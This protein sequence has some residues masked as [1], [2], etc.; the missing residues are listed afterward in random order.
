MKFALL[1]LG[2]CSALGVSAQRCIVKENPP[3]MELQRGLKSFVR[4]TLPN[5]VIVIPVVIHVLYNNAAQNI[6]V[7]QI[8]S[9]LLALNLDFRRR[10][11]DTANT[12][13]PFKS[14]AGDA[15]IAFCLAKQD[16]DGK[17]TTGIVRKYTRETEFF[18]DD[19]M[20][21]SKT[22]GDEPWDPS[23]YL[24][25]WVCNLFG[26]TLGYA[27][28]PGGDPALDGVVIQ[29]H[30]FGNEK[31]AIPPFNKGRTLTHEMGHWLGLKHLWGDKDCGS[32]DVDDTPPQKSSN[33]G[34]NTFPKKSDCSI[35]DNG[36]MFMNFMDFSNDACMNLFTV[37]QVRKMRSLFARGG[38]RNSF[39]IS[40]KCNP[41]GI[42]EGEEVPT[43]GDVLTVYPN[44]VTNRLYIKGRSFNDING[45]Q[46][47]LY[48]IQ[49]KL[50]LSKPLQAQLTTINTESLPA[51]IYLVIFENMG[52]R[53]I[54]K[55]IKT[56][57]NRAIN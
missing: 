39:L 15:R 21:S 46:I 19:K 25:I 14:V 11:A 2:L 52:T 36:D 37:G 24:N 30:Y 13:A 9:Q 12:P 56:A 10:N 26:R 20:K 22:G 32:D 31:F 43:T 53:K 33:S 4:D 23:K 45:K 44:P 57:G 1:F 54:F 48:N 27:S 7:E 50:I 28:M 34:C 6:S 55:V 40:D 17:P 29:A 8:Q 35:N 51:G 38:F 49:G 3:V 42:E 5:E 47:K 18:A 41:S 16:P